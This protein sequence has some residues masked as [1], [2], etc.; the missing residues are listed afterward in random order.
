MKKRIIITAII[1]GIAH[2]ILAIIVIG[3]S[4]GSTMESFENPDYQ[5]SSAEKISNVLA[6]I[7]IL[8]LDL[9]WSPWMSKHLPDIVEWILFLF[10]S[11]LWGFVIALCINFKALIQNRNQKIRQH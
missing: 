6:G 9:I 2:F 4:F 3:I 8:P 5:L 11:L 10:N 7:L 1:I